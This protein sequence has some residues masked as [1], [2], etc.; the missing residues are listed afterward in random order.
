[1]RDEPYFLIPLVH[2]GGNFHL[3]SG[4]PGGSGH[5]TRLIVNENPG[6]S[7]SQ[8]VQ[9]WRDYQNLETTLYT[10]YPTFVDSTQHIDMWMIPVSDNKVIISEWVNEPNASWAI[11]SDNAAAAYAARGFEVFRVPAVRSSGTHYTFT[12]AVICNDLVLVPSYSNPAAAAHNA[13]ALAVWQQALPDK[14]I[15]Q[16]NCQAIVTSAG[17]MHCIV[18]HVPASSNG[19]APAA[20]VTTLNDG[21]TLDP[22]SLQVVEWLTDGPEAP[23]GVDILLSTDSGQT[24]PTVVAAGLS[25]SPGS[26]YWSVPDIATDQA[27]IRVVVRDAQGREGFDDTDL[28]MTITGTTGC[29]PDLAEPFGTLNFFDLSAF[30]ALFNAGDAAAD[31]AEPIGTLN[32]FDVSAYLAAYNAGCP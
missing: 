20:F 32:F 1:V 29:T 19:D 25:P 17:V 22:G 24:F 4:A 27:R 14:T 30:L 13:A 3:E 8:I 6:L 5:S 2:G 15:R 16:I 31:L 21:A 10:P 7:E 9:H 23:T 18:M 28:D 11:T 12:N 26:Y